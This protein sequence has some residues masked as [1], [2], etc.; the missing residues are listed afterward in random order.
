LWTK[1]IGKESRRS[2]LYKK[3]DKKKMGKNPKAKTLL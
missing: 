1:T 3:E 2:E